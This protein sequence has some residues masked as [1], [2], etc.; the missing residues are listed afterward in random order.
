MNMVLMRVILLKLLKKVMLRIIFVEVD[1]K[2]VV[3]F[4]N[5]YFIFIW[6]SIVFIFIF[7]YY[8]C[9]MENRKYCNRKFKDEKKFF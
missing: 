9:V 2:N 6:I 4:F 7:F 1:I 5:F 3:V 8:G